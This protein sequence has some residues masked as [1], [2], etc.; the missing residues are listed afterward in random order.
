[1]L[2]RGHEVAGKPWTCPESRCCESPRGGWHDASYGAF[3][4]HRLTEEL[5]L[6]GK[7]PQCRETEHVSF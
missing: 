2:R 4:C 3:Q 6:R 7:F 1:M 5:A